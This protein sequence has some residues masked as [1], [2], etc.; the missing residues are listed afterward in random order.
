LVLDGIPIL[1]ELNV[2]RGSNGEAKTSDSL[3]TPRLL[4]HNQSK[5]EITPV[6]TSVYLAIHPRLKTFGFQLKRYDPMAL[7]L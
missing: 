4:V 1:P 6:L 2:L 5:G 3:P 7:K